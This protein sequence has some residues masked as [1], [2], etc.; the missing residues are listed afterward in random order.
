[1]KNEAHPMQAL[2]QQPLQRPIERL[3]KRMFAL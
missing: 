3:M 2:F 1:M